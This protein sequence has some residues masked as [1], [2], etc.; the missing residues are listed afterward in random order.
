MLF[1]SVYFNCDTRVPPLYSSSTLCFE[2][3]CW[4]LAVLNLGVGVLLLNILALLQRSAI[5][6]LLTVKQQSL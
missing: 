4:Y 3:I 5:F 1:R 2:V 6:L